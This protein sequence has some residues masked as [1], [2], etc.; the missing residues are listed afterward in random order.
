MGKLHGYVTSGVAALL[1]GS[2]ALTGCGG[3]GGSGAGGTTSTGGETST[4][5]TNG[6]DTGGNGNDTGGSAGDTGTGG[7][8]PTGCTVTLPSDW[9]APDWETNT[10]DTLTLVNRLPALTGAALMQGAETGDVEDLELS[11][12]TAAFEDGDPS[13]SDVSTG[14]FR[15][16]VNTSFEEFVA[17]IDV[18]ALDLVDG[19]GEWAPGTD[20][21]IWSTPTRAFNTGGLEIRQVVEK[22]LFGGIFYGYAVGLTT[23]TLDEATIDSIAAAFGA[24]AGLNPGRSND[25]VEENQN[26]FSANYAYQMG[27]YSEARQALIDAKA[28]AGDEECTAE[29]DAA[30]VHFFR[31]WEQA[32]VARHVFYSNGG[33]NG[34]AAA[35]D[36]ADLQAAL[37]AA[38]HLQAEGVGLVMSLYGLPDPDS[39]PLSGAARLMSDEDIVGILEPLGIDVEDDPA[40][41]T[42]GNF[43][44]DPDGYAE[45]V[46][47]L[48]DVVVD[49][50]GLTPA[51]LDLWRSPTDG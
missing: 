32:L 5:G 44:S 17:A 38:L 2:L 41:A 11:D 7:S 6:G 40:N 10:A 1:A 27:L 46:A 43:V 28:Y 22:G 49:V 37:Q 12:L 15:G 34:V 48:E 47:D 20:G 50:F 24:N 9:S 3:D 36:A 25:A 33:A 30:I 8:D 23:G 16:V 42:L 21:G 39:G 26:R 29:R 13:L 19:D 18:G 14:Y 4:G 45:A 31:T 51:D 35:P